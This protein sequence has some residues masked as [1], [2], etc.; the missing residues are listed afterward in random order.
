MKRLILS[1][2]SLAAFI[3][4]LRAQAAVQVECDRQCLAGF[5]DAYLQALVAHDSSNLPVTKNVRYTENGVRLNLNDGLWHTVAGMPE[6]RIDIIDE[7]AGSV[8]MLGILSENGNRNFFSARLK[9]EK[10][11]LISEIEN[12]VVRNISGGGMGNATR[13][14][15]HPLF[16]EPVPE[17]QRLSRAELV[18]IGNSYFTGLDT[19]NHGGNVPFDP[20]CQRRENGGVMAND[21]D[22]AEGAMQRL[23]CKAQFDTGF[24]VIVTDIRERRFVAVDP[25]Y[26]LAFAMGYFD[27]DGSVAKFSRTLD[28]ELVDVSPTFRQPFSFII[29]E[30]FKIKAGKIRQIE[31]VLTTVPYGMP[32]GW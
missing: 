30:V 29:A 14:E 19:D 32:S 12:L 18:T 3:I 20:D 27:H 5:L 8:A 13:R 16:S 24:S 6:Y 23:G 11:E 25:D 17:D 7:E 10:G 28:H 1:C 21:P 15:A 4:C 9:V 22:A 31:A 26:G 2:L